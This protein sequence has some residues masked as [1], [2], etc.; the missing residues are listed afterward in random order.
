[1]NCPI[2]IKWFIV[3]NFYI[4]IVTLTN[5]AM[6]MYRLYVYVFLFNKDDIPYILR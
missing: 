3:D 2:W 1:M 5:T 6:N 4:D